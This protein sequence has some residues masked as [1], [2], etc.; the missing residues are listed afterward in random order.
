MLSLAHRSLEGY[1]QYIESVHQCP[2]A[3]A[4]HG[5]LHVWSQVGIWFLPVVRSL[6]FKL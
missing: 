6:H 3:D 4:V 2:A 1:L 5:T